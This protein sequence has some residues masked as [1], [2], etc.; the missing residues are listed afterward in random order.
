M[1]RQHRNEYQKH[2]NQCLNMQ[3]KLA[4][5]KEKAATEQ[6]HKQKKKQP[7]VPELGQ[8]DFHSS[9]FRKIFV[10]KNYVFRNFTNSLIIK[11]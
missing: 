7:R 4:L 8:F 11:F 2:K 3:E 10:N 6:Q 5:L 9:L 1:K